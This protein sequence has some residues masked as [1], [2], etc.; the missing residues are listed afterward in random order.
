MKPGV[1]LFEG[2][3]FVVEDF[4]IRKPLILPDPPSGVQIEFSYSPNERTFAIQSRFE[5]S[6]SWSLHVVGSLRGERTESVFASSEWAQPAGAE[7]VAVDGFYRHMSDLGLRYGDEFRP[8]RELSAGAG[9]SAGRVAL[10]E[11][12]AL[13][14]DEYAVHPV[15][16]DGALQVFSAGAATVENRRAR[17]KL[18]VGFRRI[19]FLG[20]LGMSTRV[21]AKVTKFGDDFLE[22]DISLYNEEGKPC[23]LV[24]GFRAISLSGA[25]RSPAPGS[26]RDLTYH[27]AWQRVPQESPKSAAPP[28]ALGDL[29]TAAQE[30][31]DRVVAIRGLPE[32]E[33]ALCALDHLAGAQLA[34]GLQEMG[35]N[36]N[37]PID[38]AALKVATPMQ[39]AFARLMAGLV[40]HGLLRKKE[41]GFARTN[42]FAEAAGSA[43]KI[44]RDF[45]QAHPGHLPEALL[46]EGNCAELG[47]ILR[48]EKDAVQVLFS[49]I[50]AELLDHFYGDGLFTSHWIAAIAAAIST[51]AR[52]LPEGRG[53]RILEIGAG[54]GGLAS[55]V[56]P[57][58][59]RG[60]HSYTFSDVSA[61]FFSGAAQKLAAFPEVEFK[62]LDLEKPGTDQEFEAEAFDFIIGTNVLHAVADVRAAL[63]NLHGLL[64]SGGSLI[65]MDTATPQLWTETVFGLTSGWWH[66]TD[67]DLRPEQPLLQRAQWEKV[68]RESGFCE[69]ASLPGLIGPTGGEGQIGL[70]ARK[71][72]QTS[73]AVEAAPEPLEEK[74]WLVFADASG[75]AEPLISR[76]REL[77]ARCR[78][79]RH[80]DGFK[81]DGQDEFA[82]RP[83]ALEDWKKMIEA[84]ADSAPGRIVY[85][86]T[87]DA[88][89]DG[90]TINL[91]ALLHLTQA[92]E[93][94]RPA[95]KMRLDLI[96]RNAQPAGSDLRPTAVAQASV[97]GLIRVILNEHSNLR[98][99]AIDLPAEQSPADAAS[100][101]SEISREEGE[102]EIAVRGEARYVRRLDR[103]RPPREQW[104][105]PTLPLRLES[106]ERGRLDTLRFAPFEPPRCGPGE[107]LIEVKAAGMN[108]RDVLKALALY[109]GDAPD[110]R[111]FGDEVSGIVRA[112]GPDVMQVAPGDRVF[113]LAVFGIATHAIA[114]A[115]D[116]RRIPANL[117][118]EA[119]ATLPVVF[120]TS[121]YA[122]RNVGR[123]QK[124]ERVLVHA[125]AGGVGMA[126]IQNRAAPRCGCH[127]HSRKP[128][129]TR[130]AQK[131]S[132][133]EH[134]IDSRQRRF[135]RWR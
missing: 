55:Q 123:L 47:S 26:T 128:E 8:I 4:E 79:V 81:F 49:G 101:W 67:R 83:G 43:D 52:S 77:G 112:V 75:L 5:Q 127:C 58:L 61:S 40:R 66:L 116:V 113:G 90:S 117:T 78:V 12:V 131:R 6:V 118:F 63:R 99:R 104:L 92:L 76:L 17:M 70:L 1:Q 74:S 94:V 23:L 31:L 97:I 119:A 48:G 19:L 18:P 108:F 114:R 20:P 28:L 29:K 106:R 59:E 125:G 46:C 135:C 53:L 111:I 33:A 86:W 134:V 103:G 129:Q 124:G 25:G 60:L 96:T 73:A 30:A 121:W 2:R 126:A 44:L 10:S 110:A 130:S 42:D 15:L 24:D 122:L 133:S 32:L 88:S 16:F 35:A 69:T 120:M 22:G 36:Q 14:A 3:P 80:N 62:I 85:L 105:E 65:F 57:L 82:L 87:V 68:L 41:A 38:A 84:C 27:V 51:A 39:P 93:S 115:G 102:R 71:S 100:L 7:S 89:A 45:I 64:A 72:Y 56:L 95:A 34:R 13:R 109:P 9:Q 91:D 50:G 21:R 132:A 98:W 37:T 54:T 107:V 11:A